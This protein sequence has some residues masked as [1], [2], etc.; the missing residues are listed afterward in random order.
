MLEASRALKAHSSE[1]VNLA[2]NFCGIL[3]DGE[4]EVVDGVV[5]HWLDVTGVHVCV[6]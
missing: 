6:C 5:G 1:A 4:L 3:D 2:G